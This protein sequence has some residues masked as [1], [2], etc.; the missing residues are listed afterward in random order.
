GKPARPPGPSS[1]GRDHLRPGLGRQAQREPVTGPY[2]R[3][4]EEQRI[5]LE[6]RDDPAFREMRGV[7]PAVP[8]ARALAIQQRLRP[9]LLDEPPELTRRG[10]PLV[11]IHHVHLH[12]PLLEEALRLLRVLALAS[13]ENLY[14]HLGMACLGIG[15]A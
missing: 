14:F 6:Q 8:E 15:A 2:Q 1:S 5:L 9:E 4:A 3:G 13:A 12:A 11:E 7:Q 10:R